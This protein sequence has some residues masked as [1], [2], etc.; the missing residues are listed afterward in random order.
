MGKAPLVP[1]SAAAAGRGGD[2]TAILV[3]LGLAA[4]GIGGGYYLGRKTGG[5]KPSDMWL[6]AAFALGV[7][8]SATLLKD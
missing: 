7:V 6:L 4:A 5:A 2:V 8:V 1:A 3:T